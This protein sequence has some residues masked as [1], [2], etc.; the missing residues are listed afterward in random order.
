MVGILGQ[1][2][3]N[4]FIFI[5][6]ALVLFYQMDDMIRLYPY[7]ENMFNEWTVICPALINACDVYRILYTTCYFFSSYKIASF[8]YDKL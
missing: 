7:L 2:I 6:V 3:I 8:I 4:L 5:V 1:L